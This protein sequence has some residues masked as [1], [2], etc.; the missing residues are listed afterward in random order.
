MIDEI[1]NHTTIVYYVDKECPNIPLR[2]TSTCIYDQMATREETWFVFV[3][4]EP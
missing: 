1:V 4:V 2:M 3:E